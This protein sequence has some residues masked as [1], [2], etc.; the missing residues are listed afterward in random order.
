MPHVTHVVNRLQ[1][2]RL[3]AHS[4][5]V[6]TRSRTCF[7]LK[8]SPPSEECR[9][10]YTTMCPALHCPAWALAAWRRVTIPGAAVSAQAGPECADVGQPNAL[11][12]PS[13]RSPPRR[14]ARRLIGPPRRESR[15]AACSSSDRG[16]S[17][18]APSSL[19]RC[20]RTLAPPTPPPPRR[21]AMRRLARHWAASPRQLLR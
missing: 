5:A 12:A 8:Q 17:A 7:I 3:V 9:K 20:A 19:A 1:A 11:Q 21:L 13:S 18:R 10:N 16:K 14:R 2:L 15:P 6:V 4:L